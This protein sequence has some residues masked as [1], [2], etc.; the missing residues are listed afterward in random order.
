MSYNIIT[1]S[2]YFL[3]TWFILVGWFMNYSGRGRLS[4]AAHNKW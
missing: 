2:E 1:E 4:H 3:F